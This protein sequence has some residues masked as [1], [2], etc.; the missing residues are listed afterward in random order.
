MADVGRRC[1]DAYADQ[2]EAEVGD[3]LFPG[4][5]P[6]GAMETSRAS[7]QRPAS[8]A[9]RP[10]GGHRSRPL[11][12]AFRWQRT[13]AHSGITARIR[14]SRRTGTTAREP[15]R[16]R[17]PSRRWPPTWMARPGDARPDIAGPHRD[18]MPA[19]MPGSTCGLRRAAI[20]G[21]GW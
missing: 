20:C 7:G 18:E 15:R 3:P 16:H 17:T 12:T 9:I 1:H 10:T 2:F 14:I 21:K 13:T 6:P 11:Q 8:L 4:R 5:R 19:R